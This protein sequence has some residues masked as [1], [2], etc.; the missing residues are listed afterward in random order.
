MRPGQSCGGVR[1]TV[2][3]PD[4]ANNKD[5]DDS[6]AHDNR[7]SG[8]GGFMQGAPAATMSM[9]TLDSFKQIRSRVFTH[10]VPGHL[11]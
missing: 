11:Q 2:E 3:K 8:P 7:I 6:V 10:T 1:W 5:Q 9:E 4:T